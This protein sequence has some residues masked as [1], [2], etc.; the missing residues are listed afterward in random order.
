M[1]EGKAEKQ[2]KTYPKQW[3]IQDFLLGAHQ[4]IGGCQP[5]T[6]V[7]FGKNICKNERIGSC[8]RGHHWIRQ[9]DMSAKW[10]TYNGND[11]NS[12]TAKLAIY[13]HLALR[14]PVDYFMYQNRI[15]HLNEIHFRTTKY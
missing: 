5:P 14:P 11:D 13:D 8:W 12:N 9:C 3:R 15:S 2:E 4:A 10:A 6:Q 1:T 7:L